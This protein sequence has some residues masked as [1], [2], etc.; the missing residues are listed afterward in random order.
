MKKFYALL[1]I[2]ALLTIK[3][4]A[5]D[6]EKTVQTKQ[7]PLLRMKNLIGLATGS[8]SL[9]RLQFRGKQ[10]ALLQF[11]RIPNNNE[12]KQLAA[13]GVK[14]FDYLPGNAF[15]AELP[16][17]LPPASLRTYKVSGLY[18]M[19]PAYKI[20][21][22]VN[23]FTPAQDRFI[24]VSYF[25]DID[26]N[27]VINTLTAAGAQVVETKII[28]RQTIFVNANAATIQKLA[29]LPFVSY[30]RKQI[31]KDIPLN[32]NNRAV[33]SLSALNN[34]T[35]RNLRGTGMVIG[36]G[37][38]GDP[39][40]H[41]DFSGRLI[42]RNPMPP[43]NH[44]THT[45]GTAGSAGLINPRYR[46]MAPNSTLIHQFY[47]DIL[48]NTPLYMSEYGMTLTN[49]SY[50]SGQDNCPGNGDYDILSN[51]IDDQMLD[52]PTLLHVFAAGNDGLLTCSPYPAGFGTIKSGFQASKNVLSVGNV[53]AVTFVSYGTASRGPVYDGRLKPEIVAGG[54]GVS[55]TRV[56]NNY[57]QSWGSSMSSPTV[58]GGLALVAERYKQLNGGTNPPAMLL[59]AAAC[60]S[61]DDW[62]NAGPDFTYGFGIFNARTTVE[63]IENNRYVLNSVTQG[64]TV[65]FN[66]TGIPAGTHQLKIMLYYPDQPASPNAPNALVNNLDLTV[67]DPGAT[68][69][70]PL[71][72]DPSPANLNLPAVQGVDNRNNIEQVV[73]DNPPAG[74]YTVSVTG[75]TIPSGAQNYVVVY[76]VINP[77]VTL[78]H[79]IGNEKFIPGEIEAIRFNAYGG[80][81]NTFTVEYS[82]NGGSTWTTINNNVAATARNLFWPVPTVATTQARVRVTRNVSGLTDMSAQ[83]F[84]IL[85]QHSTSLPNLL[86]VTNP[87]P[88]YI[89]LSWTAIPSA[90][91][92]EVVMLRNNTMTVMDVTAGTSSLLSGL[93][94]DTTYWVAVTPLMSGVRGRQC[95]ARSVTPSAGAC[96]LPNFDND[97]A[98]DT[99]AAPITGRMFTSSQ[100]G[101][102]APQIRLR[103]LDD[104][105]STGTTNISYQVNGGAVVTEN[106]A[107]VI[108]ALSTFTY[109]FTTPYDFSATGTYT[110]KMW[111]DHG[112]DLQKANDTLVAVVKH[113]ENNVI[114]LGPTFTE[115]FE[116]AAAATYNSRTM[117]FAGN[118]RSDFNSNNS[119]G[120]ARTFINTGFARTGNRAVTLDQK[121]NSA[122]PTSDS[123]TTTFNLSGYSAADQLWLDFFYKNQGNDVPL[124]GNQVWIRG[125]DLGAWVPVFTLPTNDPSHFGVWRAS[126]PVNITETLA[127]AVPAQTVTSSFQVR[128]GEAGY[129][130]A[131]SVVPN[132]NLDDGFTFD[133]ITITNAQNDVGIQAILSPNLTNFCFFGTTETVQ[134][135]VKNYSSVTLNNIAVSYRVNGVTVN[136]VIPTLT[137]G[138]V[139]VHT[140]AQT[141][142]LAAFQQY[143]LD[144]WVN[145]PAD[146]YVNNDS[147]MNTI[148]H[149]TP[150]ITSYPYLEGF[151]SNNGYWYTGGIVSSWQWGA[152]AKTIINKAANGNNA[153]V[154]S[155]TGTHNSSEFSYLYSP[156]FDLSGLAQPV[157]SFSHIFR[158]EDDCDCDYHWVEYSLDDITWTKLGNASSGTNWYDNAT[159][160]AWQASN[161]L[162]HVSSY[163]VPVATSKVR[164][165]IVMRA[166]PMLNFEGVGIDDVHV[167]DKAAIYTGTD[168]TSGLVQN[169]SGSNWIHFTSGGT[170]IA[171]INPNGQNLGNTEIKVYFNSTGSDRY[172][173]VQY[174]L[175]RNIVIQPTN[176][177]S[178]NVSVR[179]YFTDT[180]AN[181]LITATGCGYCT[182]LGDAYMAGVTQYSNAP[183]EENGMLGD[184]A[185]GIHT[186]ITPANV[187]IAPYDNGY[188]AEYTVSNFS[189]FWINSGGPGQNRPLPMELGSFT[190]TKRNSTGLLEWVTIQEAN[191]DRFIIEKSYDGGSYHSIGE[192]KAAGNSTISQRYR[193]T[194]AQLS[195]GVNYYRL[196]L[197]DVNGASTYSPIRLL[198]VAGNEAII[199][200]YPNP[201]KKGILYVNTS[202]NCRRVDIT[203]VSGRLLKSIST[204]GTR[205]AIPLHQ[206]SKGTYMVTVITD[207]GKKVEKIFLE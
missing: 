69:Y 148:F 139:F 5:Q 150:V 105:A 129:T 193:F 158:T 66:I 111:V 199:T 6:P 14:L 117:G 119:N 190:V 18:E 143:T 126:T 97:F 191:T 146:N 179:F 82:T 72:L 15:L 98:A 26:R 164:F 136:E 33:H 65:N 91:S 106:S 169:V 121:I 124:P 166:D 200:M 176:A 160:Q 77:G 177:P 167:F 142:N 84:T 137:A 196:R 59:K 154:T 107:A 165:R 60:N 113:L 21:P 116:S 55:S 9:Q 184:N 79:P 30:I 188:Y 49:N 168:I 62:G 8:D 73:I 63:T 23:N 153:W 189:E 141:A 181:N 175:D 203:D 123:L 132:G 41:L 122:T 22:S 83:D 12:R 120:R 133:D 173:N 92:Y 180:E 67:T 71:I 43:T 195:N 128:F 201:V 194:D 110:V 99:L 156:C 94:R 29:T 89:N 161:P 102:V 149:T 7:G 125:S 37:D 207:N 54:D 127:A 115:G 145:H 36:V 64:N 134:V 101:I 172:S 152:P 85:Q 56:N 140:F 47:S 80:G 78:E 130:S 11:D 174:Y 57:G 13:Q 114:T 61:A 27:T 70:R 206:F 95:L 202:L 40:T 39:S 58:T 103:N 46:G 204:S 42:N 135:R 108:P 159:V 51:Y 183:A 90:T 20:S 2:V 3:A 144:A 50:F 53:S 48:V 155:L 205:Q 16:Q 17:Q 44:G 1:F 192:V 76:Q 197:I 157:L 74:N 100:L 4:L 138:Q 131:N 34:P 81:N 104:A 147:L 86:T 32:S 52:N 87:C 109:T 186:F 185:S 25:G 45:T 24:A 112:G 118:D 38:Q 170:R 19:E 88:G 10:Y 182:A 171:S 35:G 68:L 187:L 163:D 31:V 162:W 151:E 198:N 96:A 75:T 28:P 93:S 178:G